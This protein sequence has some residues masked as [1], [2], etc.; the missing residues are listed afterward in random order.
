MNT[1][2]MFVVKNTVKKLFKRLDFSSRLC[3]Y[4]DSQY[5]KQ[6]LNI[7]ETI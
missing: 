1:K 4:G 5:D 7:K 3:Y 2:I 6:K